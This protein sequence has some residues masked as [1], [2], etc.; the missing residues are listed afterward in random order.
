MGEQSLSA[1]SVSGSPTLT[2]APPHLPESGVIASAV[3]YSSQESSRNQ[4][5]VLAGRPA[6]ML[7]MFW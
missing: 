7:L 5:G 6:E 3:V 4:D 2:D 1:S